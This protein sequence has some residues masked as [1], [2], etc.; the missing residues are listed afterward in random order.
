MSKIKDHST[1]KK[2]MTKAPAKKY[3]FVSDYFCTKTFRNHPMCQGGLE[4]LAKRL[5]DWASKK[6]ALIMNDFYDQ[7][8]VPP[9]TFYDWR[10]KSTV[11]QEAYAF[12]LRRI[13]SNRERGALLRKLDATMVKHVQHKYDP[14]WKEA[15]KYHSSLKKEH[16]NEHEKV[17][18]YATVAAPSDLVKEREPD[19]KK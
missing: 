11:L 12:A 13:G 16:K 6:D 5:R 17:I 1:K 8:G 9:Q 18:V 15:D 2:S 4:R 10:H 7:E 3:E 19:E 14:L